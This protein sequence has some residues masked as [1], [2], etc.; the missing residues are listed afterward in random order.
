MTFATDWVSASVMLAAGIALGMLFVWSVSQSSAKKKARLGDDALALADLEAKRDALI[1]H[2]RELEGAEA[3]EE[4]AKI[5]LEAA[6]VL[7]EL[8]REKSQRP[9]TATAA[10]PTIDESKRHDRKRDNA[11]LRGFLWGAGSVAA[12]AL[13]GFFVWSSSKERT[14]GEPPT[15]ASPMAAA[16]SA[17]GANAQPDPQLQAIQAAVQQNPDNLE[18]HVDLARALMEREDFMNSFKETQFVLERQP[19]NA[20][21]L[22][23]QALIRLAMGQADQSL[24]MLEIA[25]TEQP[26]LVDG[27]VGL[28]WTYATMGKKDAAAAAIQQAIQRHPEQQERL[29]ALLGEMAKRATQGPAGMTGEHPQTGGPAPAAAAEPRGSA[30]GPGVKITLDLDAAAKS[31]VSSGATLFVFARADGVTSGPPIAV[32]RL[33]ASQFPMTVELTGADSMMGQPLPAKVRIEA[34][35]DADGNPLTKDAADPKAAADGVVVG[36]AVT[37]KLQ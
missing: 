18:A 12:L 36:S 14:E 17:P 7:R 1:L 16:P 24:A 22:T 15:G 28:A 11:A 27:W 31:R 37:L 19:K 26:D 8:D 9:A 25:T 32:K 35:L 2:L 29:T 6:Q 33:A 34:R 20:R 3:S 4:R 30:A 13:L 23:Y 10:I 21:A 5:E